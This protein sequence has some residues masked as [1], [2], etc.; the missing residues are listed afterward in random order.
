MKT[1]VYAEHCARAG[2]VVIPQPEGRDRESDDYIS[3]TLGQAREMVLH[4]NS[5]LGPYNVFLR[6]AARNVLEFRS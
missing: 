4:P 5:Y 1:Y 2:D 3:I 6:R